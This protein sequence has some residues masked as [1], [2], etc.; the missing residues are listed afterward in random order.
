MKTKEQ[1]TYLSLVGF[2]QVISLT[3]FG[4][5]VNEVLKPEQ[6]ATL[7]FWSM[8]VGTIGLAVAAGIYVNVFMKIRKRKK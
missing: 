7:V 6:N 4:G 3:A 1:N 5:Y 2:F 8:T